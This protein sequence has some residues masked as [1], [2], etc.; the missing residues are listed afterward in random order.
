M[1]RVLITVPS[2][3]VPLT[4]NQTN[5]NGSLYNVMI[6]WD[7]G[8]IIL[9]TLS[10]IAANDTVTYDLCVKKRALLVNTE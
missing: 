10:L 5:Y 9:E 6:E 1:N 3:E 4:H 8:D 2:H 7:T